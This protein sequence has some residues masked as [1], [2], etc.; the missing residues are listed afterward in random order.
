MFRSQAHLYVSWYTSFILSTL[1]FGDEIAQS[2]WQ[3]RYRLGGQAFELRLEQEIFFSLFTPVQTSN[4]IHAASSAIGT[5]AL[6][7]S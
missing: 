1:T 6:S 2:T 3:L 4:G 7:Q 5:G